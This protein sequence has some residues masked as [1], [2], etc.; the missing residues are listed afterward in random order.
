MMNSLDYPLVLRRVLNDLVISVPDLGF[1]KT[2]PLQAETTIENTAK[3]A[4]VPKAVEV[5]ESE[6]LLSPEL[7]SKISDAIKHAWVY[8]ED[9]KQ[10]K[11]WIPTPSTFRQSIEKPDHE[12]FTLPEFTKRLNEYMNISENTIRREIKRGA[13]KC[14]Q[15]EGGH[16]RIPYQELELYLNRKNILKDGPGEISS[17]QTEDPSH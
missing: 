14:Y 6:I 9:H 12:D 11:I 13:I 2:V 5:L 16:R 8:V 4:N 17:S 3:T 10:N 1:W 15:T 7:M